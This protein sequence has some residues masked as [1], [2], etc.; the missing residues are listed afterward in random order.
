M[1]QA[2]PTPPPTGEAELMQVTG[3]AGAA[4]TVPAA[5]PTTT[6][7]PAAPP[8]VNVPVDP[9]HHSLSLITELVASNNYDQVIHVAELGDL[10]VSPVLRTNVM[11][12]FVYSTLVTIPQ[13]G[14]PSSRLFYSRT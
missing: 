8:S 6:T 3:D 5:A 9:Y 2:P 12:L 10:N 13:A 1:S 14:S 7:T 4:G 11:C